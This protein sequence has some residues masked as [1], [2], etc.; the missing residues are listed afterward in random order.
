M[1]AALIIALCTLHLMCMDSSLIRDFFY[2]SAYLTTWNSRLHQQIVWG[3]QTL[4]L[5]FN[6]Y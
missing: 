1:P 3:L 5:V 2:L 4:G 6:N